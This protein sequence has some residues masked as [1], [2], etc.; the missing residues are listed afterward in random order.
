M[1]SGDEGK[2]Q[3]SIISSPRARF[4]P[5]AGGPITGDSFHTG[6]RRPPPPRRFPIVPGCRPLHGAPVADGR[7]AGVCIPRSRRGNVTRGRVPVWERSWD[8]AR[9]L[10]NIAPSPP[11]A[12]ASAFPPS[13]PH[14]LRDAAHPTRVHPICT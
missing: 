1:G 9:L 7:S 10:F 14:D 13:P 6:P 5:G 2:P 3:I 11:R 4:L 8:S 12:S